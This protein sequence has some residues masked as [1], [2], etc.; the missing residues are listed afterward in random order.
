ML[1]T[2][3]RYLVLWLAVALL[4]GCSESLPLGGECSNERGSCELT[5]PTAAGEA[6]GPTTS[7]GA[8]SPPIIAI[9]SGFESPL[10]TDASVPFPE[11]APMPPSD[12]GGEPVVPELP[13]LGLGNGSFERGGGISGDVVLSRTVSTLVP[14]PPVDTIF[15]ELPSWYSCIP[16]S[17]SSESFR[18]TGTLTAPSAEGDYLSFLINGTAVRQELG[19]PLT[20]GTT[21]SIE[22]NVLG[23]TAETP[24]LRLEVRGAP[25][26]CEAGTVLGSSP[27]IEDAEDWTRTC[28]TFTADEAYPYLLLAPSL[29]GTTPPIDARFYLDELRQV[30]SCGS[31]S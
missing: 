8:A 19:A 24:G 13:L 28:V 3:P 6:P 9:D 14:L 16:L 5:E 11:A 20:P 18:P 21:Y 2:P 7:P 1:A 29:E 17:I 27:V 25:A 10:A 4:S 22:A 31:S 23:R 15:A 26:L 30:A 12:A